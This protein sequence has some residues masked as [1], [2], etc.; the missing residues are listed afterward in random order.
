MNSHS[1]L[2]GAQDGTA[3]LRDSWAVSYIA[4]YILIMQSRDFVPWYLHKVIENICPYR[5]CTPMFIT[6]LLI[7]AKTWKQL[8]CSSTAKWKNRLWCF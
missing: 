1:L 6:G 7:I 5:S 3:T 2:L 4:Q 8:R